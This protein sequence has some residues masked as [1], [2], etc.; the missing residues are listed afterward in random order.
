MHDYN[1]P[2]LS[3]YSGQTI[4]KLVALEGVYRIDSLPLAVEQAISIKM[5][6]T[7]EL[8]S[9]T[10]AELTV[11]AVESLQR[12]VNNGGYHQFFLNTGEYGPHIVDALRRI[13]CD[14]AADLTQQAIDALNLPA[15]NADDIEAIIHDDDDARDKVLD[16]LDTKF[17]EYPD[18]ISER[19]FEYIKAN[20]SDIRL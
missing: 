20:K 14:A 2:F 19:L 10:V 4:D 7:W 12:E 8:S 15:L 17:Y 18:P 13:R 5:G 6:D 3:E 9:L 11:L 1:L 16:A